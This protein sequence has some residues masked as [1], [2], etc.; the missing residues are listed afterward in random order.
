[1]TLPFSLRIRIRR[2]GGCWVASGCISDFSSACLSIIGV[3]NMACSRVTNHRGLAF[4]S[5]IFLFSQAWTLHT[6]SRLQ[7]C[8]P[9]MLDFPRALRV[10]SRFILFAAVLLGRSALYL[11]LLRLC[12]SNCMHEKREQGGGWKAEIGKEAMKSSCT[13]HVYAWPAWVNG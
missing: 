6:R 3:L 13:S 2:A 8:F 9:M 1:M 10:V 11:R 4:R 7:V 12:I 5:L